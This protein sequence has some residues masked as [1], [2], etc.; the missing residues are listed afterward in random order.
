MRWAAGLNASRTS[1]FPGSNNA[2]SHSRRD[3]GA[4]LRDRDA[5]VAQLPDARE[6]RRGRRRRR[7]RRDLA[8]RDFDL[9][10]RMQRDERFGGRLRAAAQHGSQRQEQAEQRGSRDRSHCPYRNADAR[11]ATR[12]VLA[13]PARRQIVDHLRPHL[14]QQFVQVAL[15]LLQRRLAGRGR[16]MDALEAERQTGME[17]F[18]QGNWSAGPFLRGPV[19]RRSAPR[20]CARRRSG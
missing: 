19:P 5:L 12:E 6:L 18:Q 11:G 13:P 20:R 16:A 4:G 1:A 2:R 15:N 14:A 17:Q 10:R 8:A 7:R 3:R 9:V